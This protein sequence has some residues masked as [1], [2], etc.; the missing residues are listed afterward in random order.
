MFVYET[1]CFSGEPYLS[2]R[3]NFCL[4]V[5]LR[6]SVPNSCGAPPFFREM[7]TRRYLTRRAHVASHC[8]RWH[9]YPNGFKPHPH[10]HRMVA[11]GCVPRRFLKSPTVLSNA[12]Q[13]LLIE[14][15]SWAH[16]RHIKWVR[17]F[18]DPSTFLSNRLAGIL[19]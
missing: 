17:G 13:K 3:N 7:R 10:F 16:S 9:I 6:N 14:K 18:W 11:W 1:I 8:V 2:R 5:A 15:G 19:T 12:Y 4:D